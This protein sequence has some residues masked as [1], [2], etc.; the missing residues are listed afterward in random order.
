VCFVIKQEVRGGVLPC[1]RI[2][3]RPGKG[4]KR[5]K[6]AEGFHFIPLFER[7]MPLLFPPDDNILLLFLATKIMTK[8]Q[9]QVALGLGYHG[10]ASINSC[11]LAL[12]K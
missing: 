11:K 9:T 4:I 3:N 8:K 2:G 10:D 7:K 5:E 12:M 6:K 1:K